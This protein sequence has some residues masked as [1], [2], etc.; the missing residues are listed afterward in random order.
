MLGMTTR[1]MDGTY[2]VMANMARML[3]LNVLSTF[4]S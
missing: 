4:S 1:D 3:L 2:L